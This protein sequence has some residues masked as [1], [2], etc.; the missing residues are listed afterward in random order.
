MARG[1][2]NPT[3][4]YGSAQRESVARWAHHPR[5]FCMWFPIYAFLLFGVGASACGWPNNDD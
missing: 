2:V 5:R 1:R 3:P 4:R